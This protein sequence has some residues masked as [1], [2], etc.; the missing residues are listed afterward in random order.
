MNTVT[1]SSVCASPPATH[2]GE[3]PLAQPR[4]SLDQTLAEIRSGRRLGSIAGSIE[5]FLNGQVARIE[6]AI[7]QCNQAAENDRIVQRIL[8]DFEMEKKAWEENRQ[9]EIQRLQASGEELIRGW[10][11]LEEERRQW[12]EARDSSTHG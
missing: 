8:A 11:K 4:Q 9:S 10:E 3:Q 2:A 12:W 5:S 1:Q 7:D 6:L